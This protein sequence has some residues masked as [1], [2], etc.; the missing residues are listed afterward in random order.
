MSHALRRLVKQHQ[1]GFSGECGR[2]L[3][4]ALAAVRQRNSLDAGEAAQVDLIE[5]LQRVRSSN[6]GCS[7]CA[8]TGTIAQSIAAGLRTFSIT[9]RCGNTEEIDRANNAPARDV[10]GR[11]A[12]N[13]DAIEEN[14]TA[15]RR[16]E[17][18]QQVEAGR[19]AT[20]GSIARDR[21]RPT[22][23]T[24]LTA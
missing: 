22:F 18:R 19:L 16:Q 9:V 13:V 1:F 8:R 17:L 11:F 15:R 14:R 3:E 2:D 4:S 24:S 6:R 12:R 7:R 21:A 20:V 5:Q 10:L 23:L